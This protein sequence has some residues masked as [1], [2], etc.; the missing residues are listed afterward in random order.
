MILFFYTALKL[1]K[2]NIEEIKKFDDPFLLHCS[3]TVLVSNNLR[4]GFDDPFLLHCSQTTRVGKYGGMSL[5]ILFFYTA[6][7]RAPYPGTG[8]GV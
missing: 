7:K 2:P 5:M 4:H 8:S 6:L 3:Q 1:V